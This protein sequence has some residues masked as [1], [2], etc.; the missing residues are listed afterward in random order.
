MTRSRLGR[1]WHLLTFVVAV[2]A[3]VL[4]FVVILRGRTIIDT[5]VAAAPLGEQIRRF[6]CY[7]TIQSNILCAVA[8]GLI[9]FRRTQ[10]PAFRVVRLAS[11]I[12]ITVTGIVAAVALQPSPSY[13]ASQLLC[14]RLL[15]IAV[16]VLTVV[17]WV[18]FGPRG[19]V[20]RA[21]VLPALAWPVVW[22]VATLGLRPVTGWVPYP[23][24]NPDRVGAG[25][26][27]VACVVIT[28]LFLAL[29]ALVVWSDA[30]LRG[31]DR[32]PVTP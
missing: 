5:D 10:G 20:G 23:F 27:V 15:H 28:V 30:R 2:V 25:G 11:L 19:Y 8:T 12:G 3:V 13:T 4:Q 6:F 16:P 24:L 1:Y 14:D 31:S 32:E 21:D 22:L 26:V 17:G 18:A 7:F 29:A 9:V